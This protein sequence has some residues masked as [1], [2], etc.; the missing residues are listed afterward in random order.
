MQ[1]HGHTSVL[2]HSSCD[3]PITSSSDQQLTAGRDPALPPLCRFRP[4]LAHTNAHATPHDLQ[5]QSSDDRPHSCTL[6]QTALASRDHLLI[7]SSEVSTRLIWRMASRSHTPHTSHNQRCTCASLAHESCP[8]E[9][10]LTDMSRPGKDGTLD[11]SFRSSLGWHLD[12]ALLD[13][14]VGG[15]GDSRHGDQHADY[16]TDD[17][18]WR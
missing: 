9:P 8:P 12:L 3:T 16:D 13:H 17:R 18:S 2:T 4:P 6:A 14:H 11:V 1:L 15:A 10:G 5:V 7:S